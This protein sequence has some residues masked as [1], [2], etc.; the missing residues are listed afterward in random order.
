[1]LHLH[2]LTQGRLIVKPDRVICDVLFPVGMTLV[3]HVVY[4][5]IDDITDITN[6]PHY[7]YAC[8]VEAT[9]Y[10]NMLLAER[11]IEVHIPPML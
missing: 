11:G 8:M 3:S 10:V 9:G 5:D 4:A 2:V 7:V 1:M 6:A